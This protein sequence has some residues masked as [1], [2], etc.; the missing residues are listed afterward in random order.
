MN[1]KNRETQILE[2]LVTG[3][4]NKK[5]A[6]ELNISE[7]TVITHLRVSRAKYGA[8]NRCELV[9]IYLKGEKVG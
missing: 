9:A 8:Q 7:A 4:T 6:A 3:A 2:L 5:I 1:D